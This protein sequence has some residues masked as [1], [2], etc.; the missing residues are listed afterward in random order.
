MANN[1]EKYYLD[2][3]ERAG[4][5]R[6]KYIKLKDHGDKKFFLIA[7]IAVPLQVGIFVCDFSVLLSSG[8]KKGND[9]TEKDIIINEPQ[10][11]YKVKEKGEE[12]IKYSSYI[13]FD[14]YDL[15]VEFMG[16]VKTWFINF[17]NNNKESYYKFIS[18]DSVESPSKN[19]INTQEN[20]T[21]E[22]KDQEDT[23]IDVGFDDN[24]Q[25]NVSF[26]SNSDD[27]SGE[28]NIQE[29]P[30]SPPKKIENTTGGDD[31]MSKYG[32]PENDENDFPF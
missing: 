22:S 24:D 8:Y 13:R 21:R 28:N 20:K 26:P 18:K 29:E 6:V 5:P 1:N 7:N 2:T 14:S 17:W 19:Q 12:V 9:L 25:F 30:Q 27:D 11:Q 3:L 10:R 16:M 4:R 31:F 23:N 15:K 32:P